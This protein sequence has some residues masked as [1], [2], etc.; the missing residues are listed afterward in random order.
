MVSVHRPLPARTPS[1][2]ERFLHLRPESF[3]PALCGSNLDLAKPFDELLLNRRELLRRVEL[4]PHVKVADARRVH[5]RQASSPEVE[6]L[7][8]LGSRRNV[9]SHTRADRGHL[10]VGAE[11]Q[12][13]KR[14]EHLAIEVLTISLEPRIFFDFENNED[15]TFA[16]AA[17]SD[18]ADAAHRHVLPRGDAGRHFH[19]DVFFLPHAALAA[20]LPARRSDDGAFSGAGWT[21]RDA[22]DLSEERLLGAANL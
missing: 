7:A 2:A 16:P 6:H 14:D 9:K 19:R 12:L 5:P 10:H 3:L 20:A 13:R 18:V 17:G 15:V 4:K 22:D 21:G 11:H 8:A 1:R